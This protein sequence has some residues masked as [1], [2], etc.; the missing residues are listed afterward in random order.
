MKKALIIGG[1]FAGCAAAHQLKLLGGWDV[2]LVESAPYLGAGV[3][4]KYMG[5][6]PYTLGPRHF[7]TP[8]NHVYEYLNK[9]CPLR[10]CAEHEFST[11]VERDQAFYSYP[12]HA[13]DF[14]KMPDSA[15]INQEL[16]DLNLEALALMSPEQIA[17]LSPEEKRKANKAALA[18]NFEEYWIYS[19]GKSLYSKFV[20]TY[21]KKMWM[22]DDNKTIDDFAWSPKGV[23][24]KEGARAAWDRAIS[25]YP[26]APN[27][28][29]DYFDI[30]TVGTTVLLNT[31]ITH[32][33]IQNKTV[34]FNNEKH[35]YDVIV[36][37]I[38]PDL[39]FDYCYGELP[40]RGRD[41]IP[42]VLPVEFALPENVYFTYYSSDEKYT[43]V[44]EYKKFTQH[45][46]D[47]TLITLEIP[48]L[49][50]KYYPMPFKAEKA[51]ADQYINLMPDGVFSIGRAGAY[52]YGVDIDD[53]IDHAMKVVEQLKA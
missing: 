35:Q 34:V 26:I 33:D 46:S 29:D 38:S 14:S 5:G 45:K 27:G 4:T 42:I 39:L 50:G 25:A 20:D 19:I 6:H 36:N 28:Y 32:F 11:Y 31:K 52:I 15:K 8:W 12:I 22:I 7:L 44:T 37:T 47:S 18:T 30:A 23:T 49:N 43:R 41:L 21:S 13:D 51:K 40:Y 9:Y 24:I 10:R 2:T 53:T 1:G 48:S 16:K 3:R 17:K